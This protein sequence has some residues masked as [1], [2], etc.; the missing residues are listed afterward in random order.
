[1][2]GELLKSRLVFIDTSIYQKGNFQ[3]QGRELEALSSFLGDDDLTLFLSTVT[4]GEIEKHI[5]A[6]VREAISQIQS[7]QAKAMILRNVK[8]YGKSTIFKI[9]D[10]GDIETELLSSFSDFR[11]ARNVEIFSIE[12]ASA[13]KVFSNYFSGRPPF[14]VEKNKEFADAFVLESL[15]TI[16]SERMQPI[17]VVSSD[18]DMKAFCTENPSLIHFEDLGAFLDLASHTIIGAPARVAE[19]SYRYLKA[20][21]IVQAQEYLEG[22]EYKVLLDDEFSVLN[23]ARFQIKNITAK[24]EQVYHVEDGY[25]GVGVDFEFEVWATIEVTE[26]LHP[27]LKVVARDPA[28]VEVV[29]Y[30]KGYKKVLEMGLGIEFN[31]NDSSDA[32]VDDVD[33]EM[34]G[35]LILD[36]PFSSEVIEVH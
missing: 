9:P 8:K 22:L 19:E 26:P 33:L 11:H 5:K 30:L 12:K 24:N 1:M 35:D 34:P 31:E 7:F 27:T 14:S 15:L 13:E 6:K 29:T 32:N 17:Y 2:E 23:S 16:S 4:I 21:L 25:A 3:F 28:L 18:G 20:G 36:K 10:L